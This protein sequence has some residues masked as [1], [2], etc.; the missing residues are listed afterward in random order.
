MG[1]ASSNWRT[2]GFWAAPRRH[3]RRCRHRAAVPNRYILFGLANFNAVKLTDR[4][5]A[6]RRH[7]NSFPEL[8]ENMGEFPSSGWR[9]IQGVTHRRERPDPQT[10]DDSS[11]VMITIVGE[12]DENR[13]NPYVRFRIRARRVGAVQLTSVRRNY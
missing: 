9:V 2:D 7:Y 12:P 10:D 13:Q 1:T 3:A 11:T 6:G 5:W 8:L 4:T